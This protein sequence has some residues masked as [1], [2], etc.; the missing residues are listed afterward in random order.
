M[1][2][3]AE[4]SGSAHWQRAAL[5]ASWHWSDVTVN[6]LSH[7]QRK[8]DPTPRWQATAAP[9]HLQA[10]PARKRPG[11][12]AHWGEGTK[13][14]ASELRVGSYRPASYSQTESLQVLVA[15]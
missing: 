14:R 11:S 4:S 2:P 12:W 9:F 7:G 1:G 15:N 3:P 5:G 6:L 8:R 13:R 10:G